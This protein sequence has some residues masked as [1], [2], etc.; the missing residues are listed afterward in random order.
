MAKQVQH[1]GKTPEERFWIYTQKGPGCWQWIGSKQAYGYGQLRVGNGPMRAHRFAYIIKHGAIPEGMDVLH[2]CDNRSCVNPAH[3]FLGTQAD[4]I[5][6]M[7]AKG[8][9][10]TVPNVGVQHPMAKLRERRAG[11]TNSRE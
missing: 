11:S 10:R 9:R 2:R 1:H 8:R 5:A 6:D 7:D 4:N 3:L